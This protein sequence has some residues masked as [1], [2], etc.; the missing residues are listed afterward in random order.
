M[1]PCNQCRTPISNGEEFCESCLSR[2]DIKQKPAILS[3]PDGEQNSHADRRAEEQ[4]GAWSWGGALL[5]F[6]IEGVGGIVWLILAAAFF[7]LCTLLS[8]QTAV[9][10][11]LA[12]VI[13]GVFIALLASGG[14]D[15]F[16]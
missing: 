6:L 9:W 14:M 11:F 1:R 13:A 16:G 7:G 8:F 4:N 5:E 15:I 10:V 12:F 2:P 3:P